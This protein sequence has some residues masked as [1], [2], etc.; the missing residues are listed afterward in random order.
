MYPGTCQKREEDTLPGGPEASFCHP[1]QEI[2]TG[3]GERLSS[4]GKAVTAEW[5][6][7]GQDASDGSSQSKAI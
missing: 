3:R 5:Q 1:A 4:V 2:D 6:N 7:G